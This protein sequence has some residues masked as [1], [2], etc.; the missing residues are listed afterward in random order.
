MPEPSPPQPDQRSGCARETGPPPRRPGHRAAARRGSACAYWLADAGWDVAVVEKKR[1]PR[2]KTCGDG[3]T[4]RPVRQLADMGLED[5]LTGAHRYGGLRAGRLRPDARAA[6]AG[7]PRLPRLRL[8]HHPP[9]PRRP[10]VPSGRSRPGPPCWQ[11]TEALEP[12]L[13]RAPL[14]A[15]T[16]R[17]RPGRP[18]RGA[19]CRETGRH[20]GRSGP[21]T[22]WSPTAPTRASGGPSALVRD[23]AYPQ[24]MALRG[25][26]RSDRHDEPLS[27][28]TSTSATPTGTSSPATAGSSRSATG[29]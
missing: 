14:G 28:P 7:A 5:A 24:G 27:S 10:G 9:R 29:G 16:S 21:A 3:L 1:F 22:W 20:R 11:G 6:L 18:V 15:P 23:R 25:Y 19:P 13:D 17:R 2:E 8:H 26:Y 12:I 4:P